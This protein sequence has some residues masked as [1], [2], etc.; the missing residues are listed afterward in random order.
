MRC[1]RSPGSGRLVLRTRALSNL[2]ALARSATG[3]W[4]A[5]R[6]RTTVR[7]CLRSCSKTLFL[8]AG[9]DASAAGTGLGLSVAQDMVAR[10]GGIIEFES[11]Q[12]LT[13]FSMLL[14]LEESA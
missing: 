13:V 11:R 4:P 10:H 2:T 5:C 14:P 9:D 3:C 6:S 12:G 8:S 7:A 1:R